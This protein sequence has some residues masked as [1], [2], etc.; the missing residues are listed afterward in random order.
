MAR[1]GRWPERSL[2]RSRWHPGGWGLSLSPGW[3]HGR[4]RLRQIPVQCGE[5]G[6]RGQKGVFAAAGFAHRPLEPVEWVVG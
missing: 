1:K 5:V 6:D 2:R 3:L 4:R